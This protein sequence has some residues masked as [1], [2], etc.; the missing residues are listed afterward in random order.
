MKTTTAAYGTFYS[1]TI[2]VHDHGLSSMIEWLTT[3]SKDKTIIPKDITCIWSAADVRT[4]SK[5]VDITVTFYKDSIATP[6]QMACYLKT[7]KDSGAYFETWHELTKDNEYV[8]NT[9]ME[10]MGRAEDL[11]YFKDATNV[12]CGFWEKGEVHSPPVTRNKI[13]SDWFSNNCF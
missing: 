11:P 8:F 13:L 7:T 2:V 12:D 9:A 5:D 4:S 1:D 10:L 6:E 3:W